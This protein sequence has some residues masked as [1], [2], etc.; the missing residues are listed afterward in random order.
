MTKWFLLAYAVLSIAL[1][2]PKIHAGGD[3]CAYMSL[4]QSIVQGKGYRNIYLEGE[5]PHRTYPPGMALLLAPFV[6]LFGLNVI[7][8]KFVIVLTGGVGFL[9]FQKIVR[10]ISPP[11]YATYI[12]LIYLTLPVFYRYGSYVLSEM[13][14]ICASLGAIYFCMRTHE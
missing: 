2:D 1:F 4:A 13:P 10:C 8:L 3:T 5:P 7:V 6:A 11:R 12:T 14:Y 9:F